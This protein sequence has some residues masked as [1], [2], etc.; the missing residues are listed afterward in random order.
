MKTFTKLTLAGLAAALLSTSAAF[1]DS[2]NWPS[3]N[4]VRPSTS[5]SP[6]QPKAATTTIAFGGSAK[7]HA[8]APQANGQRTL[9]QVNTAHGTVIYF[10]E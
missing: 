1:A 9:H 4:S 3:I 8:K 7:A 6:S 5:A 10:A 2:A